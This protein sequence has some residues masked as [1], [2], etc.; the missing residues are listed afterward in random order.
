MEGGQKVKIQ[1]I[2]DNIHIIEKVDKK[3]V[4]LVYDN[5]VSIVTK[6]QKDNTKSN[7]K[8]TIPKKIKQ[9]VWNK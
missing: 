5:L 1:Y 6:Y 7:T 3:T 4:D 9:L 8:Q 2:F